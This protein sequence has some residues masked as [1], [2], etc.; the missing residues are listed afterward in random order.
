MTLARLSLVSP[1]PIDDSLV[2]ALAALI[3]DLDATDL[4]L[5]DPHA[6]HADAYTTDVDVDALPALRA[7]VRA[8][9]AKAGVDA[10]L[11]TGPL[12]SE[13]P[14]LV[15]MDVDS[16]LIP[17]E[18]IERIAER[19]G[20]RAEVAAV[21]ERAMRGELDF[22]ASLR[23]RVAT[24]AGVPDTVF[25]DVL[26]E[27]ELSPGARELVARVQERG[28]HVGLV[29][30]GFAEVVGPLAADLGIDASLVRANR[31]GVADGQLTGHTVGDVVD[32]AAKAR[33]LAEYA[34]QVGVPRERT[35]AIGDGAND[36]DM[37][38]AAGLG[39]AYCA[40]PVTREAAD[41]AVSFPRL[42]A[43]LALVG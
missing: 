26:A 23:E 32:R 41:A 15:V 1:D 37:L 9:A 14:G 39:V 4:D 42:D 19:A 12:A 36:L 38:A 3:G 22:A 25:A 7:K 8:V 17:I 43:A 34:A 30:G 13:G 6:F 5:V 40:K 20:A 31:L 28:G 33:H 24:L 27:I 11:V 2:D 10:A 35:L 18:V 21:T 29:S 16:T